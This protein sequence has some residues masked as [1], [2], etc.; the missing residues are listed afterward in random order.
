M[1]TTSRASARARNRDKAFRG[2]SDVRKV[3]RVVASRRPGDAATALLQSLRWRYFHVTGVHFDRKY[4][5][6]TSAPADFS[7]LSIPTGDP[8]K[9]QRYEPLPLPVFRHFLTALPSDL[10]DFVFVDFGCGK[11][12]ALLLASEYD[13]KKIIGVEFAVELCAIARGNIARYRSPTRKCRDLTVSCENAETFRIPDEPCVLFFYNPFKSDTLKVVVGN[14]RDSY[15]AR[16]RKIYVVYLNP[17]GR[18]RVEAILDDAGVFRRIRNT[19][20]LRFALLSPHPVAV[21]ETE[22]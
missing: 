22:G 7:D 6:D 17:D 4:D 8:N 3:V 1:V 9:S 21:Y 5:V 12:R 13:F 18:S 2:M 20:G 16:P 15:I 19:A 14:I 10:H 11:G